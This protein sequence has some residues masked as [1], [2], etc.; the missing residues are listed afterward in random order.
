MGGPS[1]GVIVHNRLPMANFERLR[2]HRRECRMLI[3]VR[4]TTPGQQQSP[5]E[6]LEPRNPGR[7]SSTGTRR[8]TYAEP[9]A[10]H[11]T[12]RLHRFEFVICATV[13]CTG[14]SGT[15]SSGVPN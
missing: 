10:M 5:F 2:S 7:N 11:G 12:C 13:S 3:V 8:R 9:R 1:R 14:R 6:L 4:E 15:I